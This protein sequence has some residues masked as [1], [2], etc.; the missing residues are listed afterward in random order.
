LFNFKDKKLLNSLFK[1]GVFV[2]FSSAIAFGLYNV[3]RL[4]PLFQMIQAKNAIFVYPLSEW[5]T[6]PFT[7]FVGN[8]HGLLSWLSQ[9]LTTYLVLIFVSLIFVK[10]YFKEKLL[11]FLYFLIPFSSFALFGRVI[12]PRHMFFT[13]LV[14]L[15]LAAEGL[16]NLVNLLEERIKISIPKLSFVV[17]LTTIFVF[18]PAFTSFQVSTNPKDAA[19]ADSDSNQYA[20]S[21]AA[22]WGLKESVEYFRNEAKDKQ[23]YIATEGTF[24]LMPAALEMYLVNNKNVKIQGYWPVV[25]FPADVLKIAKTK[26]TYFVFYQPQHEE[27]PIEYPL[28][29]VLKVKQGNSDSYFRVYKVLSK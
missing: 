4:S 25:E 20:N 19:I 26:A 17:I 1:W 29:L 6:H 27:I 11:L 5:L 9:Y 22:G 15:P 14:L 7:F 16:N 3:L 8:L 10:K 13:S 21:W 24:G 18:Y 23:I 12:F 2:L 28:E